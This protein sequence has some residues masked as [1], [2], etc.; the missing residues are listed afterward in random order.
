VAKAKLR[1]PAVLGAEVAEN[2][3]H[4]VAWTIDP[5]ALSELDGLRVL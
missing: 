5:T 2:A 4:R 1:R 3:P